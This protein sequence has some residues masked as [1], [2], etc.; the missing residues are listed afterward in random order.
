MKI[1]ITLLFVFITA[2]LKAQTKNYENDTCS[3]IIEI[4]WKTQ[5]HSDEDSVATQ[6]IIEIDIDSNCRFSNPVVFKGASNGRNNVAL[7]YARQIIDQN[8]QCNRRCKF[9]HCT[10]RKKLLPLKFNV[11][12]EE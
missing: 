12:T 1:N 11:D 7:D 10:P 9:K 4:K 5:D 2:S 6:V 3:C 8:N